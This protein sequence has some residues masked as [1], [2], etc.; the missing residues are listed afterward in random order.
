MRRVHAMPFGAAITDE[1]V[2]FALWAPSAKN[3]SLLLDGAE[4]PM[5]DLGSGWRQLSVPDALAGQR[6]AFRI[7]GGLVVPDPAARFQPED[8]HRASEVIDPRAY[9]WSDEAWAGRP[10]EET[11]LYELHVGTATREGT[12]A[13]LMTKLEDLKEVGITAIELMPIA[14][15]PGRRNWG[16][17]EVLPFAPD[18][19]Y[20]SPN[21]LKRLIDRAHALGLSMFLDVVYNHFGPS[22]NYLG[23]YASHFFTN[24]YKTPWGV[25]INV[26]GAETGPVRDFIVHNALYWLEEYHFDGLR[27]DAVHAI[28]DASERHILA[29]VAERVRAALPERPSHLVLEN[30]LNE[31]RWLA[32]DADDHPR[33]YTAQWNDDLHHCWHTLL[34]GE[35]DG[36]YADYADDPVNRL[37]RC[38]A[39]GFGYQGEPSPHR[40]HQPRGEQSAHLPPTAFVAFL[41]N[42][43]QI[44][45]RAFGERL[46]ALTPPEKLVL[47]RAGLLL[48]PQVPMLFMGEEWNASTPFLF[49]VDFS[50][51]PD[52]ENAVRQGRQREFESFKSFRGIHS[53][54]AIPDPTLE[55]TF[56]RS[57]LDWSELSA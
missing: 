50:D 36:Y 23:A 52:L 30:D 54:S 3:V 22:G 21:D 18:A 34:T 42:H 46:T 38:L 10:W 9:A 47:A 1:G 6:Y 8:V 12:F 7:D 51:E 20:G 49:F 45:N 5:P 55:D 27:F 40:H 44:G 57:R 43:D 14:E 32:R 41:Q 37:G 29:E 53:H 39:E 33:F 24:R 17:D 4:H 15:F 28:R 2:R 25:G 35:S 16:Y 11:V 48:L 31:A 26:D 13:A 19:A 56:I